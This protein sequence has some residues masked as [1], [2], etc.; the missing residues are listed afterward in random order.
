[1]QAVVV[2]STGISAGKVTHSVEHIADEMYAW[3]RKN[4]GAEGPTD[5]KPPSEPSGTRTGKAAPEA[6]AKGG[7][8]KNVSP[9]AGTR[10][11]KAES[12]ETVAPSDVTGPPPGACKHE[13]LS[14]WPPEGESLGDEASWCLD[15]MK[16]VTV[17]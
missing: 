12:P 7:G 10:P 3:L 17:G 1:M 8:S 6:Q 14:P 16:P 4:L 2:Q 5:P 11:T 9:S 15:C 13:H